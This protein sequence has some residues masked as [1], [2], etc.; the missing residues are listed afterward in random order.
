[1]K[2]LDQNDNFNACPQLTI[3]YNLPFTYSC[4]KKIYAFDAGWEYFASEKC[5]KIQFYLYDASNTF[6]ILD[7]VTISNMLEQI[8]DLWQKGKDEN[9]IYMEL[10]IDT[11][12]TEEKFSQCLT[13][14]KK[15]VLK[16]FIA[17]LGNKKLSQ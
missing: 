14:Y 13:D 8:P 6:S 2:C 15:Y 10:N 17:H 4:R 9:G 5:N 12:F 1:M 11:S 3:S 16:P 7:N